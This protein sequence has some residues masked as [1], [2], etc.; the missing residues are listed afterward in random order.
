[1]LAVAS[2]TFLF[3]AVVKR[4][5]CE[6]N[7]NN[8]ANATHGPNLVQKMFRD[9]TEAMLDWRSCTY[10]NTIESVCLSMS[11]HTKREIYFSAID[12]T[13]CGWSTL[14]MLRFHLHLTLAFDLGSCF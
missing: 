4:G 8:R 14:G 7:K 1:M 6:I 2:V 11:V 13:W 9:R 12:V 3:V 10:T 5:L